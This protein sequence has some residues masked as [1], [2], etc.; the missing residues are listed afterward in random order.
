MIINLYD[1]SLLMPVGEPSP[2]VIHARYHL[3]A[4]IPVSMLRNAGFGRVELMRVIAPQTD[5]SV[6]VEHI[7]RELPFLRALFS[8][9]GVIEICG[10]P[11]Q[12]SNTIGGALG[13]DLLNTIG[14]ALKSDLRNTIGGALSGGLLNTIG[15]ALRQDPF[16]TIGGALSGDILLR[17]AGTQRVLLKP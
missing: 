1:S 8:P 6:V 4:P 15:G 7:R 5:I 3:G 16:N 10:Q 17:L 9:T 13:G 11:K 12:L 2:G 14:G